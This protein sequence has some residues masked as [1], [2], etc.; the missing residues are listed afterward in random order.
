MTFK[1]GAGNG[2][3]VKQKIMASLKDVQVRSL[4][5]PETTFQVYG[6]D[7]ITTPLEVREAIAKEV[8]EEIDQIA[9][10]VMR[11]TTTE[12]QVATVAVNT[13]VD[14]KLRKIKAVKIG[15]NYCRV[16]EWLPVPRCHRCQL[17]GHLAG[18]CNGPDR[19]SCCWNC[20][21]E[22]HVSAKCDKEKYCLACGK[23]GHNS[24]SGHCA[25]FKKLLEDVKER[26]QGR[27]K[28]QQKP[29][30]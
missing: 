21:E 6:I 20:G 25:V 19:S 12:E 22:G 11:S 5:K 26:N 18:S 4:R 2:E 29:T 9:V 28:W 17:Y 30:V 14:H 23:K 27:P 7:A 8:G 13:Q 15:W 3:A 1:G 10:K 16:R 24:G